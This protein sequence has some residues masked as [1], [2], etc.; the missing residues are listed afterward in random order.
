M[1]ELLEATAGEDLEK[2]DL[3][4]IID[5]LVYKAIREK[6]KE[7][8][9]RLGYDSPQQAIDTIKSNVTEIVKRTAKYHKLAINPNDND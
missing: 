8:W 9:E 5:G 1:Q 3:V 6:E 2:G 7:L 4:V